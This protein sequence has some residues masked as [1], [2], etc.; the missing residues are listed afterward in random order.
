MWVDQGS[1]FCGRSFKK[2]L[3][4][5]DIEMYSTYNEGKSAIAERFIRTWKNNIYMHMAAV[6]NNVYF[7]EW[8][9]IVDKYNNTYHNIS[10]TKPIDV[11]N[12][13]YAEYNVHS[14]AKDPKL[15]IGAHVRISKYNNIFAIGYAPNWS[16]ETF[17]ISKIKNTVSWT[18][19][20][21]YLNGE[22][23]V[24]NLYERNLQKTNEEEFRTEKVIRRK[25]NKLFA[26]WKGYDNSFNSWIDK[27]D[28]V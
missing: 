28:V 27:K 7:D 25:G 23:T 9:N 17:V 14:N 24:A 4:E 11:K 13:F 26:K 10:K 1:E 22:E 16:E 21:N 2:R 12:N 5:N 20:M 6:S 19:V 3:E 15:K 8:N 18:Y